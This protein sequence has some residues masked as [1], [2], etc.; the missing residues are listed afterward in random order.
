M[1]VDPN[2]S[3]EDQ[4]IDWMVLARSGDATNE[5]LVQLEEWLEA[6]PSHRRA[7]EEAH[8]F[9]NN[10]GDCLREHVSPP[11]FLHDGHPAS[12]EIDRNLAAPSAD[13]NSRPQRM[14]FFPWFK[15]ALAVPLMGALLFA[16][17][18]FERYVQSDYSTGTGER[19]EVSLKDGSRLIL[20]TNSA[21][22]DQSDSSKR[23]IRL[24]DGQV[25]FQVAADRNRPFLV[26]VGR[27]TIRSLGT[28]FQVAMFHD[29]H[30]KVNVSE[31]AVEVSLNANTE[32]R[33]VIVKQ[34]ESL[35]YEGT[36]ELP[37]SQQE[38]SIVA[39]A[40]LRG[41][42]V[43][44]DRP[45]SEVID[46]FNRYRHGRIF[47]T[48]TATASMRVSGVFPTAQVDDAVAILESSLGIR[49]LHI[50]PFCILLH[51]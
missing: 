23:V 15:L 5:E 8:G 49:S 1:F 39:G 37:A 35:S 45:L 20:D 6:D 48:D 11:A 10:L 16:V 30:W 43:F 18:Y 29:D 46:T 25:A 17:P 2:Q 40:W 3:I 19:K 50:T 34:G 21:L 44:N 22:A 9:W 14:G 33:K 38:D 27:A 31:H 4:A 28:A 26:K 12:A 7:F 42:L 32:Q 24:L 41:K 13:H 51:P 36:V 47:I